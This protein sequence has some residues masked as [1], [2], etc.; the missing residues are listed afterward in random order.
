MKAPVELAGQENGEATFEVEFEP[1]KLAFQ[2][3][4]VEP[5]V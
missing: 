3:M 4:V 2:A 1:T 5:E